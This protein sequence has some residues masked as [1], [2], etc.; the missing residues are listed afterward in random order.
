MFVFLSCCCVVDGQYYT[1]G[2]SRCPA[3]LKPAEKPAASRVMSPQAPALRIPAAAEPAGN[4]S[5]IQRPST[6]SVALKTPDP[7]KAPQPSDLAAVS[8]RLASNIRDVKRCCVIAREWGTS[9]ALLLSVL[10]RKSAT[11]S[12]VLAALDSV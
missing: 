7:R 3:T 2:F 11:N 4:P 8:R 12:T 5:S 10:G 6:A 9:T 1:P